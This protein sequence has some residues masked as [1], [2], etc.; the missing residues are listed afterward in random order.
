LGLTIYGKTP[1]IFRE[2]PKTIF[3]T[4]KY[5]KRHP[6]QN[7]IIQQLTYENHMLR[8]QNHEFHNKIAELQQEFERLKHKCKETENHTNVLKLLQNKNTELNRE[9]IKKNK[10]ISMLLNSPPNGSSLISEISLDVENENE[11][12]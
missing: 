2:N 8:T 4:T 11:K 7:P 10:Q 6:I 5:M 3:I 1:E 9:L 12:E